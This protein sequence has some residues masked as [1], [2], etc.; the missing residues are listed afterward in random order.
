MKPRTLVF[1]AAVWLLVSFFAGVRTA[2]SAEIGWEAN[3]TY[4]HT[5]A[6]F[7]AGPLS[8]NPDR[9]EITMNGL[10]LCG[11]WFNKLKRRGDARWE[12]ELCEGF[13]SYTCS[14]WACDWQESTSLRV[15]WYLFGSRR[16]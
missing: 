3:V 14:G 5:S 15:R 6:L 7:S 2:H 13:K 16:R 4:F 1:I 12:V 9:D 10:E 8:L 11:T